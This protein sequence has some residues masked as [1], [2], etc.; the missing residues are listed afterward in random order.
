VLPHAVIIDGIL[1]RFA[2]GQWATI[3]PLRL[4][5]AHVFA[6]FVVCG[7]LTSLARPGFVAAGADPAAVGSSLEAAAMI[8]HHCFMAIR[9][10]LVLLSRVLAIF[11]ASNVATYAGF[12]A[13]LVWGL[14][15]RR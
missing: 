2:T 12:L 3:D 9:Y 10:G 1:D 4:V 11:S 15:R 13:V 6:F 14:H 8:V 5:I 7:W